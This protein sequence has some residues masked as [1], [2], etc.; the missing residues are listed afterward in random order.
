[1]YDALGVPNVDQ[2]LKPEDPVAPLDPATENQNASKA[3]GGQGKLQAFPEQ[4][5]DAHI[6]VHVGY[7]KSAVAQRQE[8]LLLTLE[9]H[10]YEHLGLKAQVMAQQQ[11]QQ[12]GQQPDQ[13]TLANTIAQMQGQLIAEYL[14]QNPPQG[15]EDPLV[16][17]KKQE[18]ALREQDQMQ[19]AQNDQQRLTLDQQRL[20][21]QSQVQRER[22]Q[23]S[24]DIASMRARIALQRQNQ[25]QRGA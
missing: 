23:S 2:I 22:I 9:K 25:T 6:A 4:D 17:L 16:E 1:M 15:Q 24:E 8:P 12:S 7:M 5:H 13:I 18:L 10:V 11:L 3:A 19:D 20:A 21:E 14:Q